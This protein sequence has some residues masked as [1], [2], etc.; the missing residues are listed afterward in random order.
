MMTP[1]IQALASMD[2]S[3]KVDI[4]ISSKWHDDRRPAF[5]D[6]FDKWDIIEEVI[7]YPEMNFTKD[8][9]RWF[10]TGHS[11]YFDAM[12]IFSKK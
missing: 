4:C 5:E 12:D 9:T 6:F 1:A 11:E 8:Y 7:N 3:G 2:S 10:Y